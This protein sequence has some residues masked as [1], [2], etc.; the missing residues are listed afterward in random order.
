MVNIGRVALV[1]G[2]HGNEFT[3]VYLVKKFDSFPELI[4]QKK[5]SK[6]K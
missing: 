6:P 4:N 3:G 5:L 1:G 2:T